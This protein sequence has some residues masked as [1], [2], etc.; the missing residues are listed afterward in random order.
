MFVDEPFISDVESGIDRVIELIKN[1]Q[2]RVFRSCKGLRDEPGRY[3][4][5]T[6]EAGEPTDDIKDKNKFHRSYLLVH[7]AYL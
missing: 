4:R 3:Q 1:D 5:K 2:L 7:R 6:D